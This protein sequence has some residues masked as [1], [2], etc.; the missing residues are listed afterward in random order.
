MKKVSLFL[1]S[2]PLFF[3]MIKLVQK[4]KGDHHFLTHKEQ[5]ILNLIA[6]GCKDKEIA[7]LLHSSERSIQ[8]YESNALRKMN[9]NDLSSA[10][11]YALEKGLLSITYA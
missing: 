6:V 11:K 9:M 2:I 8:K 7:E 3:R 10:I 1:I 5:E 4:S